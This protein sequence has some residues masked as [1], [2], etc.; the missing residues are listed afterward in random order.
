MRPCSVSCLFPRALP[1][2]KEERESEREREKGERKKGGE[3]VSFLVFM[4]AGCGKAR[5]DMEGKAKRV[6]Q[7]RRMGRAGVQIENFP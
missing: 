4:R 3:R 7:G 6:G 5:A 2:E 1:K